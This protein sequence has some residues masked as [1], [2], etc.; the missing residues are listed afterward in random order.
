MNTA[1]QLISTASPDVVSAATALAATQGLSQAFAEA[2]A[3]AVSQ[4]VGAVLCCAVLAMLCPGVLCCRPALQPAAARAAS[5]E[6]V[7]GNTSKRLLA[8][9]GSLACGMLARSS[10]PPSA[11]NTAPMPRSCPC[12]QGASAT[13]VADAMSEGSGG[14]VNPDDLSSGNAAAAA[15]A[16]DQGVAST[17]QIIISTSSRAINSASEATA[18]AIA[19]AAASV[20]N[21]GGQ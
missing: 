13:T 18:T 15:A 20:C 6:C 8:C 21:G 9:S 5:T 14:T 1:A 17:V 12:E 2:A 11:I 7:C 4:Q 16:V 3:L 10:P 19:E